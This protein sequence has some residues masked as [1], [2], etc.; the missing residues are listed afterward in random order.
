MKL[1]VLGGTG[2]T[3]QHIVEQGLAKGHEITALVRDASKVTPRDGLT[4]VTGTPTDAD[5]LAGAAEGADAILVALN[6]PRTSDAP[7]AKPISTDKILTKVAQNIIA[8][9]GKRVVFLSAAGVGDSFDTAPWFMRFMIKKTN[10]SYAYAD[11]NAVEQAFRAS[12]ANW[13]LVRA[14]GLS[15]GDKEK[16]L[17]VGTAT[18]PKPGMMI[19]RSAVAA[20]MLAAAENATQIRE[21]P[22]ISEK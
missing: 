22:V 2:R 6:N 19:R 20:F 14:M 9:G 16:A 4:V 21:T 1:L 10:L 8:L 11:H 7:W 3:G 18:T 15:N 12:D 13:T 17:V 5:T